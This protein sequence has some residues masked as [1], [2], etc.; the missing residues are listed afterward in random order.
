[1]HLTSND[2]IAGNSR[3]RLMS[4]RG[5]GKAAFK[6][7]Q[8][9][10]NLF[11]S[12]IELE[13]CCFIVKQRE[14]EREKE[15]Q[16]SSLVYSWWFFMPSHSI[17]YIPALRCPPPLPS[18]RPFRTSYLFKNHPLSSV[19]LLWGYQRCSYFFVAT[20]ENDAQMKKK[21]ESL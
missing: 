1:M 6:N 9:K 15:F 11:H 3:E 19:Q 17:D 10:S 21:N 4:N 7:E 16:Q 8:P 5:I 2:I 18:K 13:H 12:R 14:R 20:C